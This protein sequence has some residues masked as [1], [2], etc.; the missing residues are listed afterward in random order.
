LNQTTTPDVWHRIIKRHYD[1]RVKMIELSLKIEEGMR[2]YLEDVGESNDFT[3]R[4][5]DTG[6]AHLDCEGD[7]FDLEQI[8]DFCDVFN[9]KLIINN[10]TVVENHMQDET[11]VRTKYLFTTNLVHETEDVED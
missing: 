11:R 5:E 10:R 9:L 3:L 6:I 8:G 7:L 2:E 4:F 1:A